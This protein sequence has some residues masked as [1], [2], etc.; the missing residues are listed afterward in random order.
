MSIPHKDSAFLKQHVLEH[1]VIDKFI[2][3][4]VGQIV[5]SFPNH[6]KLPYSEEYFL[7]EI[8]AEQATIT[9]VIENDV[10]IETYQFNDRL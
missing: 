5:N 6:K 2:G 4:T 3:W 10:C 8:R 7:M 1:E 9:C